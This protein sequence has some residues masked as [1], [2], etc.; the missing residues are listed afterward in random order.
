AA[1]SR[2]RRRSG[3][4]TLPARRRRRRRT[5]RRARDPR[6]ERRQAGRPT[7]RASLREMLGAHACPDEAEVVE[8]VHGLLDGGATAALEEHVAACP[9]CRALVAELVKLSFAPSVEPSGAATIDG[10][11]AAAAIAPPSPAGVT[12]GR[13]QITDRLGAGGM[14][15]VLAAWDPQLERKVAVKLLRPVARGG[16]ARRARLAREAQIM[17]RLAHPNVCAV[18]DAGTFAGQVYVVMEL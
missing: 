1:W 15:V 8:F 16:D 9:A 3:C 18:Y 4:R 7:S 12:V 17:A 10:A 6:R 2:P 11:I 5:R 13:Y 14:G